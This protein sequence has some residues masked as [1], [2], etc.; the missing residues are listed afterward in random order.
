MNT[1]HDHHHMHHARCNHHHHDQQHMQGDTR[2]LRF[3]VLA[4][5]IGMGAMGVLYLQVLQ[6]YLAAALLWAQAQQKLFH[7][8]LGTSLHTV[9]QTHSFVATL[10]IIGVGFLYGIFHA[11]G[12]GHGKVLVTG[13]LLAGRH[14]LRRSI[15]VSGASSLLQAIVAIVLVLGLYQFLGLARQET[16]QAAIWL[17]VVGYA[18]MA[19][20]GFALLVRGIREAWRMQSTHHHHKKCHHG[21]NPREIEATHDTKSLVLMILSIGMRPCTGAVLLLIF[22]CI[23]NAIWAGVLATLAMGVGTFITTATLAILAIQSKK[24]LLKLF[25]ASTTLLR[26]IHA[27]LG[28]VAGTLIMLTAGI[29]LIASLPQDAKQS[30]THHPLLQIN[31]P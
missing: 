14:T 1:P 7:A 10:S 23:V 31:N 3:V 5:L 16:E 11:V 27:V 21:I 19:L 17:E 30:P 22:S 15:I 2:T 28:I 13:Y 12:P 25:G 20:V 29:F 26:I 6:D 18:L 24:G 8:L 9:A 4:L